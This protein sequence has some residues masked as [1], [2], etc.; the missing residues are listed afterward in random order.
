MLAR[1]HFLTFQRIL[2]V[3]AFFPFYAYFLT[4]DNHGLWIPRTGMEMALVLWG[5]F[6]L[7]GGYASAT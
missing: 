5:S 1:A 6:W 7:T 4:A 3:A 2:F